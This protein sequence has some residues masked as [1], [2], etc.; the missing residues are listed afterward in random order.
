[1]SVEFIVELIIELLVTVELSI[2]LERIREDV[3]FALI[4]VEFPINVKFVSPIY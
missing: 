3:K 1:M 4:V 2:V